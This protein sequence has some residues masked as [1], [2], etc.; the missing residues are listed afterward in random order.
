MPAV[1]LPSVPL[2]GIIAHIQIIVN[3][4]LLNWLDN[5]SVLWYHFDNNS[6]VRALSGIYDGDPCVVAVVIFLFYPVSFLSLH[7]VSDRTL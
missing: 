1:A 2:N 4:Y 5:L 3:N 6:D 7:A